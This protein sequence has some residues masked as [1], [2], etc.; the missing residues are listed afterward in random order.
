MKLTLA[1]QAMKGSKE[2]TFHARVKTGSIIPPGDT[3]NVAVFPANF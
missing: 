3:D 2:K 1:V